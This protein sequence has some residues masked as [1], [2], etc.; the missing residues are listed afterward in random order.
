M[1]RRARRAASPGPPPA[2]RSPTTP[3]TSRCCPRPRV[4]PRGIL[5]ANALDAE[6]KQELSR[7]ARTTI[8]LVD[9]S[10]SARA[11][12]IRVGG[13]E[14][15]DVILTDAGAD[16]DD[17]QALRDAGATVVVAGE[18]TPVDEPGISVP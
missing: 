1:C 16:P 13:L 18:P 15:V 2:A 9:H 10:S 7:A 8:L 12:P 14:L 5:C 3:S 11:A 17:L 4:D 6:L